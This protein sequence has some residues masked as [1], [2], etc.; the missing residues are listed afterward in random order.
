ME[1]L[2]LGHTKP[3]AF[4]KIQTTGMDF[5]KDRIIEISVTR[6]ETDG[7]RKTGTRLVNPEM[8]I[9]T[10]ATRVNNITDAMV[11]DK[12]VFKDIAENMVK[13]LEGCDIVGFSIENFDLKFLGEEFNKAGVEFLMMGRKVIDISKIYHAMEA[14]DLAAAYNFYCDK[15][16]PEKSGSENITNSYFEIVNKMFEKYNGKE[17]KDKEEN[18]HVIE[19]TVESIHKVFNKNVVSFDIAGNIVANEQGRPIVNFGKHKGVLVSELMLNNNDYYEWFMEVSEF[20]LDTKSI[21]KR[22]VEKAKSAAL[23]K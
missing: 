19:P 10:E 7:K 1:Q 22:I 9:P 4:I 17:Y 2:N 16:M 5:K 21:V 18:I 15:K 6:V 14:R 13:F 20:P 23:T 3:L 12:P 8:P 11:K